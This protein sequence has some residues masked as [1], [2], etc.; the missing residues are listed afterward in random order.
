MYVLHIRNYIVLLVEEQEG[1][2]LREIV[3][4]V[5]LEFGLVRDQT[6]NIVTQLVCDGWL[7]CLTYR[8]MLMD[9]WNAFL[10]PGDWDARYEQKMVDIP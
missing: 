6:E 2:K 10:V 1:M 3:P 5:Y 8:H 4:K 7:K 9:R